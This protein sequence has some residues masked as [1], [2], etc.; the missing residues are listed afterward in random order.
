MIVIGVIVYGLYFGA[1]HALQQI[2]AEAARSTVAG[3]TNAE[4]SGLA[5]RSVERALASSPLFR[6]EDVS[7]SVGDDPVDPDIYVV[8]LSF[9]SR[10]LG[11]A[12]VSRLVPVPSVVLTR[13]MRVR[14]G[15]L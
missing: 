10:T 11:F 2:T 4:R 1:A 9:D 15:G 5:L 3:V 7:V 13:S 12:S 14:R 8:T 6:A